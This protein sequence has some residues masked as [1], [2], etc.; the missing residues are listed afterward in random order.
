MTSAASTNFEIGVYQSSGKSFTLSY[1]LFRFFSGKRHA[2]L[3]CVIMW[4]ISILVSTP[5]LYGWGAFE[6]HSKFALCSVVWE[7]QHISY[8]IMICGCS[9]NGVTVIIF[10]CYYRIYKKVKTSTANVNSHQPNS[11]GANVTDLKLL[12]S[13]FSVVCFFIMTWTPM[14]F[15][16][17]YDTAGGKAP[18]AVFAFVAYLMFSSSLGN[19]VI[20]GILN[21]KFRRAFLC[22]LKCRKDRESSSSNTQSTRTDNVITVMPISVKNDS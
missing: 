2:V 19:P 14:T 7:M 6:Y 18:R 5:P 15:M 21:P 1:L 13:T 22:V 8:V 10:T 20:Y 4:I 16:V 11:N 9:V 3:C 12:K 17:I